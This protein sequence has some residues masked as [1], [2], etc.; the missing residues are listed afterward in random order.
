MTVLAEQIYD[1]VLDLPIEE[2]LGLIDRLVQSIT[3]ESKA[4]Q[5]AWV[6]EAERRYREFKAGT[7]V[8]IPGD[9]VFKKI[10]SRLGR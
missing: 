2:R 8:P 5:Q 3:P 9:E 6:E 4:V 1:D 7:A 10:N